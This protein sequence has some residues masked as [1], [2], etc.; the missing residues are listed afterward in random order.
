MK[1][2]IVPKQYIK[3]LNY[4]DA[5]LYCSILNIDDK[6]DWRLPSFAECRHI[7]PLLKRYALY[8]GGIRDIYWINFHINDE[9][10]RIY[11][12]VDDTI[13]TFNEMMEFYVC[14]IRYEY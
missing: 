12:L 8:K 6:N 11:D 10:S 1:I 3:K 9:T 4:Q 5:V 2:E 7:S 13:H 14:P